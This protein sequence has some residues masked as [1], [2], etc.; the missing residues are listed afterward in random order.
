MFGFLATVF[1]LLSSSF[2]SLALFC[3]HSDMRNVWEH[4]LNSRHR[5][6]FWFSTLGLFF[7]AIFLDC[8]PIQVPVKNCIFASRDRPHIRHF[9]RC[10]LSLC[11]QHSRRF[12]RRPHFSRLSSTFFPS[13]AEGARRE[14]LGGDVFPISAPGILAGR[15]ERRRTGEKREREKKG[16]KNAEGVTLLPKVTTLWLTKPLNSAFLRHSR[17]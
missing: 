5:S 7:Q 4:P 2:S 17:S 15:K 6:F 9:F 1:A 3:S 14:F 10:L 8:I 12:I 13:I 11:W 16:L